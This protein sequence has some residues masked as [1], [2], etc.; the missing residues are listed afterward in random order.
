M[1]VV[2]PPGLM[3]TPGPAGL[4]RLEPVTEPSGLWVSGDKENVPPNSRL[5]GAK[6]TV[7]VNGEPSLIRTENEATIPPFG[8]VS[9]TEGSA[10]AI[11]MT[12][13]G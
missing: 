11:V 10:G 6:A 13:V 2:G 12:D 4:T 3:A 5:G 1:L 8:V 9:G 7:P